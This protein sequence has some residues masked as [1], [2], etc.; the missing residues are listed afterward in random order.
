MRITT[1]WGGGGSH[2]VDAKMAAGKNVNSL[3][4]L[5]IMKSN[6][7]FDAISAFLFNN[8]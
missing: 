1:G 3:S 7:I 5:T 6:H 2:Q 4:Q 8:R